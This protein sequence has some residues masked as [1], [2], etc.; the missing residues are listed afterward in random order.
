M[1]PFSKPESVGMCPVRTA[2]IKSVFQEEVNLERLPGA[3]FMVA[4]HGQVALFDSVGV[5][6]PKLPSPIQLDDIF[7]IYSMTKPLVSVAAMILMEQG[8]LI[9]SDSVS[10][11]LPEFSNQLV[12]N[13]V[14]GQEVIQA[15]KR[16]STIQDLLLHTSG[17]PYEYTGSH[18][19]QKI[20]NQIRIGARTRSSGELSQA[21]A[22]I[23]LMYEPGTVWEYGRST[24]VLGRVIEVISGQKLS[25]FL[26]NSIFVPLGM[27]DTSFVVPAKDH[28]RIVQPFERDPE[29]GL[30]MKIHDVREIVAME[31]GGGGLVST[32]PDYAH[33]LQFML[34]RGELNGCRLLGPHTVDFM[35]C[36]HLV[37]IP[38]QTKACRD[39]LPLGHGFGLGFAVRIK[40]GVAAVPTSVGAYFWSGLAGT[41]FFVDPAQDMFAILMLQAP[42]QREYYRQLFRNLVYSS[43][44]E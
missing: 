38:V 23:P 18:P 11:Y 16:K 1:L 22:E 7:R 32:A 12:S 17:I 5:R 3:V 31:S 26:K 35:T 36:D 14:D 29:G 40:K 30:Q 19:V 33:F 6:D 39:L 10:K 2:K 34:N 41:T 15:V 4:R 28:H 42:N 25:E 37:D 21:I 24:D 8:K 9:L 20:Y 13:V 44:L 43:M 27:T